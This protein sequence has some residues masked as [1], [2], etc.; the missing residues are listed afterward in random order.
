[1]ADKSTIY[2]ARLNLSDVDQGCYQQ[3]DLTLAMHPSETEHRLVVRLIAYA[4]C[5]QEGLTFTKGICDGDSPDIWLQNP[6]GKLS[7]WV[8]VGLPM[9]ER[10]ESA[11]RRSDHVALF[12]Y[13]RQRHRWERANLDRLGNL[14]NLT[15]I[16]LPDMLLDALTDELERTMAWSLTI[17][18]GI[19]Y[20]DTAENHYSEQLTY[21]LRPAV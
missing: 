6:G 16:A 9:P 8:E 14:D 11:C 20:L 15:V 7:Q 12:I 17:T 18:D 10:I 4:L 3:L 19:L 5:Y 21:L 13:G 1:M 2:K